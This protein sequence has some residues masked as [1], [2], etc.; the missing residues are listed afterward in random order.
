LVKSAKLVAAVVLGA[1]LLAGVAQAHKVPFG[2]AETEIRRFTAD[3]CKKAEG[4]KN[5][6][7]TSCNRRS[8][9]RVDCLST[10]FFRDGGECSFETIAV[11]PPKRYVVNI[12][13]KRIVC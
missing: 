2:F 9:H 12:H 8:D 1:L 3:V 13:H 6:Q 5:W 7:V 4:C 10:F 11:A